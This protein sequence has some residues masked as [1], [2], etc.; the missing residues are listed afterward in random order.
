MDKKAKILNSKDL[1]MLSISKFYSN[2]HNINK[3]LATVEPSLLNKP[4]DSRVSLRLIDWFVTNYSKKYNVIITK[5]LNNNII[6][7]NVHLSYRN[8]L[9]S[10][11]K[12]NFDPFRRRDRI[13][14]KFDGEKSID[15]T[16]GQLNMFKW[17]IENDILDYIIENIEDIEK[18][19]VATQKSNSS[20]KQIENNIK[21]KAVKADNGS[22]VYQTRKKR[23]Q[24]SKNAVKNMNLLSGQRVVKFD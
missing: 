18:D 6:H 7:F 1:M 16:I 19:M 8:Q 22:I 14:F 11:S 10:Y 24:L 13:T 21:V 17:I 20:K 9:K 15:T 4:T 5:K 2:K 3:M 23:N 12:Q